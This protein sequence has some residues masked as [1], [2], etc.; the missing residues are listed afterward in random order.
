M[1]LGSESLSKVDV[2]A[3]LPVLQATVLRTFL[4]FPN[5]EEFGNCGSRHRSKSAPAVLPEFGMMQKPPAGA[6][7]RLCKAKRERLRRWVERAK[8][9]I[10]A[11]PM[12]INAERLRASLGDHGGK[13]DLSLRLVLTHY[14]EVM[15]RKTLESSGVNQCPAE[16]FA[17]LEAEA[18]EPRPR[19]L[20]RF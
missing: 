5:D 1:C 10:E 20:R 8:A 13:H 18:L 11:D 12:S 2:S 3:K 14:E 17:R 16:T 15:S 9:D 7:K 6:F 19:T 4:H